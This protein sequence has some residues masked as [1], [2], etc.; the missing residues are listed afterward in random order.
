MLVCDPSCKTCFGA[1]VT[2]C[3]SCYSGN[4]LKGGS[5]FACTDSNAIS[6]LILDQS[7][8]TSCIIG[9]TTAYYLDANGTS[10][11]GGV[12]RACATN[13][14]K[15]DQ[16]GPG[17][18][19][20][21]ECFVGYQKFQ[22]L[23]NCTAC[24]YGCSSCSIY[25]LSCHSCPEGQFGTPGSCQVCDSSCL[26]CSNTTVCLS[27]QRGSNLINNTCYAIPAGCATLSLTTGTCSACLQGY[28]LSN[29]QCVLDTTCSA[30]S[31]CVTCG[32][33]FY[34]PSASCTLC[35]AVCTQCPAIANCF[36]CNPLNTSKCL[37]CLDGYYLSANAICTPCPAGCPLCSS[38]SFCFESSPGYYLVPDQNGVSLGI[39]KICNSPCATCK[40]DPNN[41]LT[42]QS[43]WTLFGTKCIF[44][45]NV[46][47]RVVLSGSPT[48]PIAID[49]NV[50]A[51]NLAA[52]LAQINRIRQSLCAK[53]PSANFPGVTLAN[54]DKY[55]M[56]VGMAG[57]SLI[58][59]TIISGGSFTNNNAASS[60]I[61]TAFASN[62]VL[63][64]VVVNS[65]S[66]SAN[67]YV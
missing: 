44:N 16:N 32:Q 3:T 33:G 55:I 64:G 41:C 2:N 28:N 6:C 47:M 45:S 8:S 9:F 50:T 23:S 21:G 27:C 60:T 24:M 58:V 29:N 34:F 22:G 5:C 40:F 26:T 54:C 35:P 30:N 12:C 46:Q 36:T 11:A 10:V 59:N 13:C 39:I 67:G 63:D 1:S 57:G 25:D 7:F 14:K 17:T 48:S 4:V 66:V 53:L 38:P 49:S 43:G 18:C 52:G 51:D 15:C 20:D 56:I 19:D 37:K 31:T 42:C 62:T 61:M 65:A